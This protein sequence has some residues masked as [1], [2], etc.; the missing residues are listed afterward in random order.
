[1]VYIAAQL[2]GQSALIGIYQTY[3]PVFGVSNNYFVM[4]FSV[5]ILA[6]AGNFFVYRFID[7]PRNMPRFK[8]VFYIINIS[9]AITGLLI[10]F[11]QYRISTFLLQVNALYSAVML[12]ICSS[13]IGFVKKDYSAKILFVAWLIFLFGNMI[14]VMKDFGVLPYNWF[15]NNIVAI[16]T[17][18]ETV[19][20]SLA[21]ADLINRMRRANAI[22]RT[23][24]M[25]Q[26]QKN[27]LLQLKL[28]RSELATLQGQM[29]PHFV[30]N[31]LSSIQND[32]LR[33]DLETAHDSLGKFARLMRNGLIH[34]RSQRITLKQEID[35]LTNYFELEKKRFSDQFNFHITTSADLEV[36]KI[37]IPPL[38]IQ[39]LC[40]NAIKHAFAGRTDGTITLRFSRSGTNQLCC[41]VEDDGIGINQRPNSNL[42]YKSAKKNYGLTIVKDRIRLLNEQGKTSSYEVVDLSTLDNT[43]SG[44]K[45]T[46]LLPLEVEE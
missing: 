18:I 27:S 15:T 9:Y 32:I 2:I 23:Q 30:F 29:N 35:F 12:I 10:I 6:L 45:I 38:M 37:R 21:L 22:S 44:T 39:P 5:A 40:E 46:L 24:V 36:N 16:G 3:F 43:I 31:A 14:Y 28:T 20:I 42:N 34:S 19:L 11:G 4:Y 17:A 33:E 7:I 26:E 8:L 41:E 25:E 13:Y 1:V